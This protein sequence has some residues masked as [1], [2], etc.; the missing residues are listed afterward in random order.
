MLLGFDKGVICG[1]GCIDKDNGSIVFLWCFLHHLK[2]PFCTRQRGE[3]KI[4]LLRELVY[5]KGRLAYE[6]QVAGKAADICHAVN[7]HKSAQDRYYSIVNIGNTDDHGNH[8]AGVGNCFCTGFLQQSIFF[9]KMLQAVRFMVEDFYHLLSLNQ[10]L[11]ISVQFSKVLLLTVEIVGAFFPAVA[12]VEKH[13]DIAQ[14]N[15]KA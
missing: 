7:S 6:D 1:F 9:L 4:R 10:L 15:K 12:N 13:R 11:N 3:H 14:N 5:R 8:R 2:D